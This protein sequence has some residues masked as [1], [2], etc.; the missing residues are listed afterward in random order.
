MTWCVELAFRSECGRSARR[1]PPLRAWPAQLIAQHPQR[2]RQS[3]DNSFRRGMRVFVRLLRDVTSLRQQRTKQLGSDRTHRPHAGTRHEDRAWPVEPKVAQTAAGAHAAHTP[4]AANTSR[5]ATRPCR[6]RG[7]QTRPRRR[8]ASVG[9]T[10][11]LVG[12]NASPCRCAAQQCADTYVA[13]QH[14]QRARTWSHT[15]ARRL[16]ACSHAG[17]LVTCRVCGSGRLRPSWR[18]GACVAQGSVGTYPPSD[19]PRRCMQNGAGGLVQSTRPNTPPKLAENSQK[20]PVR[21]EKF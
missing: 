10:H 20:S 12:Q 13:P 6:I 3:S 11:V 17:R 15:G 14:H 2:F 5:R 16:P 9:Q 19:T 21:P 1:L 4:Q 18:A 7:S 8:D